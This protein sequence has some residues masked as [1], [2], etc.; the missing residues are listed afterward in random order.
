MNALRTLGGLAFGFPAPTT[1]LGSRGPAGGPM[2]LILGA[3]A[4]LVLAASQLCAPPAGGVAEVAVAF[5]G[6]GQIADRQVLR[7]SGS[8]AADAAALSAAVELAALRRP[9]DVAGR[10]LLF[11]TRFDASTRTE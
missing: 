10:T 1:D 2:L 3:G 8:R 6:A 5:D 9:T 7:S 11:R 4:A